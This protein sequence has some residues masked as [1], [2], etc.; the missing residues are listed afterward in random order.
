MKPKKNV[1][2][3]YLALGDIASRF[4]LQKCSH[5]LELTPPRAGIVKQ[6]AELARVWLDVDSAF[7]EMRVAPE[8][9]YLVFGSYSLAHGIH[10]KIVWSAKGCSN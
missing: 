6:I 7:L 3:P 4:L 2:E 1:Y 8:D 5:F 10:C 9:Q